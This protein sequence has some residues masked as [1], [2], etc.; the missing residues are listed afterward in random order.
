MTIRKAIEILDYID[1]AETIM[2]S[3]EHYAALQLGIEA[4]KRLEKARED[5]YLIRKNLLPGETEE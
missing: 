1:K 4:L 3:P 2:W 5:N